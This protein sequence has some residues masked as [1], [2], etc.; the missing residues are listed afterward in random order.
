M[1]GSISHDLLSRE[2]GRLSSQIGAQEKAL[3]SG[4]AAEVVVAAG[5]L[6][7]LRQ[8]TEAIQERL[9]QFEQAGGTE[10]AM[11]IGIELE[12]RDLADAFERWLDR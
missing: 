10:H 3:A 6:A 5:E 2:L 8:R 1:S 7:E 9:R 12:L 4:S 11:R